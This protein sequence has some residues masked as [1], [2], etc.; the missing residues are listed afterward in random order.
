MGQILLVKDWGALTNATK[1]LQVAS[2]IVSTITGAPAANQLLFDKPRRG[3]LYRKLTTALAAATGAHIYNNRAS[4]GPKNKITSTGL[5]SL[6]SANWS[7]FNV[8]KAYGIG[9]T[10]SMVACTSL[11]CFAGRIYGTIATSGVIFAFYHQCGFWGFEAVATVAPWNVGGIVR[12]GRSIWAGRD[13]GTDVL[14]Y[15]AKGAALIAGQTLTAPVNISRMSYD[16]KF[17]WIAGATNLY[18]CSI[19]T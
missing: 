11:E 12:I 7:V 13:G 8:G 14:V 10:A 17:L 16:G 2:G 9:R 4:I 19:R 1:S 3:V 15:R 6:D 18:Q 5:M